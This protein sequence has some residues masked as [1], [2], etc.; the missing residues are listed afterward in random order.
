MKARESVV[1]KVITPDM[2]SEE[3][4]EG[5]EFIR[6]RPDWRSASF[7]RFIEKL[8]QRFKSKNPQSLAKSRSY[9]D[10]LCKSAPS[11]IPSWMIQTSEN[12]D[13]ASMPNLS[14]EEDQE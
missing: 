1:W 11:G 10:P 3:E 8:E 4:D 5:E 13:P 7:N 6:H 2:M 14:D 9:G 12:A